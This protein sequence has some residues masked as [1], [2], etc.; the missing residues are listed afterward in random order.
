MTVGNNET[1]PLLPDSLLGEFTKPSESQIS[2]SNLWR[3]LGR[4]ALDGIALMLLKFLSITA[5]CLVNI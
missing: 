5:T 4:L 3:V 1:T 2:K